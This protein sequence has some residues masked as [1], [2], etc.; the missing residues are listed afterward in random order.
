M[1]ALM[2]MGHIRCSEN[3]KWLIRCEGKWE[4]QFCQKNGITSPVW[5]ELGVSGF[6]QKWN[7]WKKEVGLSVDKPDFS[8]C[9]YVCLWPTHPVPHCHC[10]KKQH[11][12]LFFL[13]IPCSATVPCLFLNSASAFVWLSCFLS[14][15]PLPKWGFAH[16]PRWAAD[17]LL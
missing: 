12:A 3:M 7:C 11:D 5:R 15:A 8:G 4:G 17:P 10:N 16:A 6:Q 1:F 14:W 13:S 2:E 9:S